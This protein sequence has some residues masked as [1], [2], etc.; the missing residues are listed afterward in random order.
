[1]LTINIAFLRELNTRGDY[2]GKWI[3]RY[4]NADVPLNWERLMWRY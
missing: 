1:M 2:L 3:E 4:G